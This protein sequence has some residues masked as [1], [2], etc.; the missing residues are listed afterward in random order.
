[1]SKKEIKD[2]VETIS[3]FNTMLSD[4]LGKSE[5]KLLEI[6]SLKNGIEL[7]KQTIESLKNDFKRNIFYVL[8]GG[9]IGFITSYS[10][11]TIQSKREDRIVELSKLL[12]E[13]NEQQADFQQHMADMNTLILELKT[14]IDSL[15]N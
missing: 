11:S 7:S 1:M 2:A 12:T 5:L 9:L 13:K 8:L 3:D 15:K 6:R 10:L 14:E 4:E